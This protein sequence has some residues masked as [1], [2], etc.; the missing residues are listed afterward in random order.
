MKNPTIKQIKRAF[1]NLVRERQEEFD[2]NEWGVYPIRGA[3]FI[4]L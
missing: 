4:T 3:I 1:N 2:R